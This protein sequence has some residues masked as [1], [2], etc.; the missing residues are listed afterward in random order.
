[1][2]NTGHRTQEQVEAVKHPSST[3]FTPRYASDGS[4][5]GH[6]Q[7]NRKCLCFNAC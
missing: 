7:M 4:T 3:N 6:T 1:M 2:K 5:N